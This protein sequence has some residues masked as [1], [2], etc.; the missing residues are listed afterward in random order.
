MKIAFMTAIAAF[1]FAEPAFADPL[2]TAPAASG[3]TTPAANSSADQARPNEQVSG[4]SPAPI[5]TPTQ[6][7][8]CLLN[9][10]TIVAI[11][12]TDP[13]SASRQKSTEKFA[14]RLAEPILV[15][16]KTIVP[17]GAVGIGEVVDA[18]GPGLGGKPAKLILAAR[19]VEFGGIRV[20]LRGLKLGAGGRNNSDV[21]MAA[22]F[23]VGIV[24]FLV[25]GGDA[26][27]PAGTRAQA[28]IAA[29]I[30]M[31]PAQAASLAA[32]PPTPPTP[33]TPLTP[34]TPSDQRPAT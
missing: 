19:Y 31:A 9:S 11:E 17:A 23:A 6:R 2:P 33:A 14:I 4:P 7:D 30:V 13:L 10:G 1:A 22:S 32:A 8:C 28:K 15:D 18:A 27:I 26:V 34:S 3:A 21:S 24:G 16:G 12:I 25:P 5:A 20:P 29:N